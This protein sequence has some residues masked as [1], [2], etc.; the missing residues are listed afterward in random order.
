MCKIDETHTERYA[1]GRCVECAKAGKRRWYEKHKDI[2]RQRNKRKQAR[3]TGYLRWYKDVPCAD[4]GKA[5]PHYVMD[6]HHEDATQ[7]LMHPGNLVSCGSWEIM[8]TELAK[9]TV[10]CSNCHRERTYNGE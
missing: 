2:Y 7:K 6:L 10:L 8:L 1:N 9:C 5:Y 4:C 3:M